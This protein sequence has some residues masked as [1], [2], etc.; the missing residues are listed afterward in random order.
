[1]QGEQE[2]GNPTALPIASR[3]LT[4]QRAPL[5]ASRQHHSNVGRDRNITSVLIKYSDLQAQT[6]KSQSDV[7]GW[8]LRIVG[9][10]SFLIPTVKLLFLISFSGDPY[11][12]LK[13]IS[14]RIL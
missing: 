2:P 8:S 11:I 4:C 3:L 13:N 10:F 6:Q 9:L 1:M 7:F 12:T 5:T 14:T